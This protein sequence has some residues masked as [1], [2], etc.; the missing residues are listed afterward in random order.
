MRQVEALAA[1]PPWRAG[2]MV[3][4]T[5]PRAQQMSPA[6]VAAWNLQDRP[7]LTRSNQDW[8]ERQGYDAFDKWPA[9]YQWLDPVSGETWDIDI[10]FLKKRLQ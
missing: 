4:D 7:P 9:A 8:Y 6:F 3:L 10:L 2:W 5:V 1:G